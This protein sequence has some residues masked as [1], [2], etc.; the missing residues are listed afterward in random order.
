MKDQKRKLSEVYA[1]KTMVYR[2]SSPTSHGAVVL[3]ELMPLRFVESRFILFHLF[4]GF[5]GCEKGYVVPRNGCM[6]LHQTC[7]LADSWFSRRH[8]KKNQGR[9]RWL[10]MLIAKTRGSRY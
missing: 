9:P 6:V 1:S 3:Y 5:S 7:S 4:H 10:L 2:F 8:S